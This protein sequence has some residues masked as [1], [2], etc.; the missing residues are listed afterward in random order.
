M[1]GIFLYRKLDT[2]TAETAFQ[3]GIDFFQLL[4]GNISGVGVK[5]RQYLRHG[6]F[7]QVGHVDT[8]Y[9]LVVHHSQQGVQLVGRAVDNTQTV[10]CEV[11]GIKRSDKDTRY[12]TDCNNKRCETGRVLCTHN[13]MYY[14]TIY[15]LL[16]WLRMRL[17]AV[18]FQF[19]MLR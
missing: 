10:S 17:E 13:D 7:Y 11:F 6:F 19:S 9:I 16:F 2:D 15:Y 18:D 8:V 1:Y 12:Y 4:C 3:L 14:F 5:L